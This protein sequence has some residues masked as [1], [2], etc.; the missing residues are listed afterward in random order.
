MDHS[1]LLLS[2]PN[3]GLQHTW[4]HH[5]HITM[6]PFQAGVPNK[7]RVGDIL[8]IFVVGV[9][10]FWTMACPWQVLHATPNICC[11]LCDGGPPSAF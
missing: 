2:L 7:N 9:T 8:P 5:P 10:R 11:K 6:N 4:Q 3:S 1:L